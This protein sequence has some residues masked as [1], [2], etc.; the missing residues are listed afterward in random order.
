MVHFH[1]AK[2]PMPD[3]D[4]KSAKAFKELIRVLEAAVWI[5]VESV[6]L[7]WKGSDLLVFHNIGNTGAAA[8]TIAKELQ[9]DVL[10][11]IVKRAQLLRRR[12]GYMPVRLLGEQYSV[13]V[14]E[15]DHYGESA[16]ILILKQKGK[17]PP[18]I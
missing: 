1:D 8:T 5:G 10:G 13:A 18:R 14:E 11:E 17:S 7:E 6:E 4:D 16:F 2:Q 12:K 3:N 9:M 15:Y